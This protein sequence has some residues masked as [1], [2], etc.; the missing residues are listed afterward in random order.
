MLST[1]AHRKQ[2]VASLGSNGIG[3]PTD[4]F[5]WPLIAPSRAGPDHAAVVNVLGEGVN[6]NRRPR[7][8]IRFSVSN[9]S[10]QLRA[11]FM[12]PAAWT[13]EGPLK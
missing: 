12:R 5:S 13:E 7:T 11:V 3:N 9:L 2:R 6:G 4:A 8:C 10:W 1:P